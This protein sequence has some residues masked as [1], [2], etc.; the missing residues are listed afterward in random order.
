MA[1]KMAEQKLLE[2]ERAQVKL[3][4]KYYIEGRE[5]VRVSEINPSGLPEVDGIK[6]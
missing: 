4:E 5:I 3:P 1:K 6:A 2:Q